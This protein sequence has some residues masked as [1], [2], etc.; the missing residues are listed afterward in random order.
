MNQYNIPKMQ[1]KLKKELDEDRYRH[2]LGVMYTSAALAMCYGIDLEKAQVA[3]LLHDC[4]K[5]IPN[6]KKIKLC[7]KHHIP[8]SRVEQGAPFL[9]HSKLGAYLAET[10]YEVKEEDILQAITWHT[11]GKPEMTMLEKIVFLADYI[12]PMRW[13]ASNLQ[14]IR[15]IAFQDLDR[16]VYMTLRDTL[17][18]LEKG[19]G[20]VDDMTRTAYEYYKELGGEEN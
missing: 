11:T 18:Y 2:T 15:E 7:E 17:R 10:K 19:S 20:E 5:C 14:E 1:R 4:A 8:I 6:E 3:G 13:K 12:E 16:A 9:L